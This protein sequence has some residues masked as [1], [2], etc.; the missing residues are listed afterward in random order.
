ML[1]YNM[2]EITQKNIENFIKLYM[3]TSY[4]D[5]LVSEVHEAVKFDL[6]ERIDKE[7]RNSMSFVFGMGVGLG[8]SVTIFIVKLLMS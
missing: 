3:N 4:R 8:A 6:Q 2:T 7:Y 5:E 1:K